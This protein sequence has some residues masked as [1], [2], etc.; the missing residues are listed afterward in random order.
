MTYDLVVVGAGAGGLTAALFGALDGLRVLVIEKSSQIGGTTAYSSGS[1][2][3]PAD[4][5]D[6]AAAIAY[7]DALIGDRADRALRLRYVAAARAVIG[8][9]AA[10][11]SVAFRVYTTAPDYR[12]E[13]PGA[14]EGGRSMEPLPFDGRLLGANFD[15]VRAPIPELTLFGGMMVTRAEVATL[16]R[17]PWSARAS[18]LGARLTLRYLR[19]RLGYRRGTRLVLGNALAARLYWEA[20]RNGV[21]VWFDARVTALD[22]D[23]KSVRG[24]TLTRGSGMETVH[25]RRGVVLAGGGFP[26]GEALRRRFLPA[27]VADATPAF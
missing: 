13:L 14:R 6:E 4:E 20:Q 1:V 21:E 3:I 27:P 9:L 2:W 25:A 8:E 17:L 19:D 15:R 16:L 7:L 10:R 26:A 18:A 22:A 11:T 12:P 24:V 5:H 23:G